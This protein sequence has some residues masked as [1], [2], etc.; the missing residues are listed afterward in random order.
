LPASDGC[1]SLEHIL[2]GDKRSLK[3]FPLE[4][5]DGRPR[6]LSEEDSRVEEALLEIR[7]GLRFENASE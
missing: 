6:R 3:L 7:Q 2:A 5:K 4:E 1:I